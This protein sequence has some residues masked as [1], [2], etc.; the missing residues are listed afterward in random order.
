MN[1]YKSY[2]KNVELIHTITLYRPKLNIIYFIKQTILKCNELQNRNL[3]KMTD[4]W[5]IF[6]FILL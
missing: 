3:T 2:S 5:H 4:F 1:F 6:I